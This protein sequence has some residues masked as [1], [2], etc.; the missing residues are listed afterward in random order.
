MHNYALNP[1]TRV[2]GTNLR[3]MSFN[4][5]VAYYD[6]HPKHH[7]YGPRNK[8]YS[9]TEQ[10]EEGKGRDEQ[11]FK[12]IK[13]YMPDVIGLQEIDQTSDLTSRGISDEG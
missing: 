5:L 11:A 12:T 13:R 7:G 10:P 2:D 8:P 9:E 6:N 3:V 1:A 4:M